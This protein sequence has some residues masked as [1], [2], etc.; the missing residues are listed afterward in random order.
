[1]IDKIEGLALS[2]CSTVVIIQALELSNSKAFWPTAL[3]LIE[4]KT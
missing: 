4:Q 3:D 2:S 1:M